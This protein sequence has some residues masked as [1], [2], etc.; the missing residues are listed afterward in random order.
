MASTSLND[1]QGLIAQ[2]SIQTAFEYHREAVAAQG[3]FAD[4][5]NLPRTSTKT[6]LICATR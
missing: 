2:M 6:A 5:Y 3:G 1:N 4:K